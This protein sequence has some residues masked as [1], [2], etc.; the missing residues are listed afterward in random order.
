[1]NTFKHFD[2]LK[3][4]KNVI[5]KYQ[6][7]QTKY[8]YSL[9]K[10]TIWTTLYILVF[11]HGVTVRNWQP[12]FVSDVGRT[13]RT[14][15]HNGNIPTPTVLFHASSSHVYHDFSL[16]FKK[17][18]HLFVSG[19]WVFIAARAFSTRGGVGAPLQ[20]WHAGVSL[21]WLLQGPRAS[22]V[23]L[24]VADPGLQSTGSVVVAHR[25]SGSTACGI[26]QI[27]D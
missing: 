2:V 23:R 1:M 26:F 5:Y 13:G 21:Q 16:F 15:Q 12:Q 24:V 14:F 10:M 8:T 3:L 22:A 9:I 27:R 20:L 18:A 6:I 4:I 17:I 7:N 19:C 25:L 11:H